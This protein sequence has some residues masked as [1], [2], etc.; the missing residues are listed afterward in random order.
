[1]LCEP[2]SSDHAEKEGYIITV[3]RLVNLNTLTTNIEK[4]SA[5]KM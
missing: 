5:P 3:K 1:M 2:S 4:Y